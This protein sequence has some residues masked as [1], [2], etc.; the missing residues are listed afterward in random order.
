MIAMARHSCD[1]LEGTART[2]SPPRSLPSAVASSLGWSRIRDAFLSVV[3]PA[4]LECGPAVI[5]I[6]SAR[7]VW[8]G[9]G[10][11]FFG[12]RLGPVFIP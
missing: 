11:A 2:R 12:V 1:F 6:H 4:N 5:S 9:S 7:H 3:G 10:P 8:S